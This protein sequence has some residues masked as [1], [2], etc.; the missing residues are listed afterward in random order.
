[1]SNHHIA[2]RL[3]KLSP[4]PRPPQLLDRL[5]LGHFSSTSWSVIE[6]ARSFALQ[7]RPFLESKDPL[8]ILCNLFQI[9]DLSGIQKQIQFFVWL[10]VLNLE[11]LYFSIQ[12]DEC[13][14]EPISRSINL[15]I[16]QS[17]NLS[18]YQSINLSIYHSINLLI[19]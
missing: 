12:P 9:V 16:Y 10:R 5:C 4:C 3:G 11:Y 13:S 15:S 14:S 8:S 17:I 19:Y 6:F 2:A 1:M 18:I 7:T